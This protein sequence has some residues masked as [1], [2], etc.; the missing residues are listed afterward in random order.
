MAIFE[1]I[2]AALVGATAAATCFGLAGR[3]AAVLRSFRRS[4]GRRPT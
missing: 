2:A 1:A 4:A 3:L